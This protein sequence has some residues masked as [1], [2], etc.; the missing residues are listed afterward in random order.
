ML[1]QLSR[2]ITVKLYSYLLFFLLLNNYFTYNENMLTILY[3][4][5]LKCIVLYVLY[6]TLLNINYYYITIIITIYTILL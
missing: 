5:L 3:Y 4:N 1:C 6:Y 2:E